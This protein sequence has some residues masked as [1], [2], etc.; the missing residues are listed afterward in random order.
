MQ[1]KHVYSG[2]NAKNEYFWFVLFEYENGDTDLV[3]T[4]PVKRITQSV[5]DHFDDICQAYLKHKQQETTKNISQIMTDLGEKF[6][7]EKHDTF[8]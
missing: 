6:N 3:L 8:I 1:L 7:Y 5:S 4:M 2:R